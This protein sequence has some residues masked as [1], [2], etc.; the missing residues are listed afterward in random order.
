MRSLARRQTG[1]QFGRRIGERSGGVKRAAP[2][3]FLISFDELIV[4][5]GIQ[6]IATTFLDAGADLT[7]AAENEQTTTEGNM[8]PGFEDAHLDGATIDASAVGAVEIGKN[9]PT[10]IF[11]NL[12]V[13]SADALVIQSD[14]VLLLPA[15]RNRDMKILEALPPFQTLK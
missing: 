4:V 15:D 7:L 3:L 1:R 10:T 8:V 6:M 12:G 9:R 11:L 14:R 5:V 2:L 13:E